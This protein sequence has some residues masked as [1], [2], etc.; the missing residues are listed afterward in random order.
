MVAYSDRSAIQ[1]HAVVINKTTL[2]D[3]QIVS[4]VAEK[5]AGGSNI[6]PRHWG[7]FAIYEQ[8]VLALEPTFRR[9]CRMAYPQSFALSQSWMFRLMQ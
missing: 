6:V 1:H 7:A 4:V 2:T 8:R 9:A 3:I 5:K